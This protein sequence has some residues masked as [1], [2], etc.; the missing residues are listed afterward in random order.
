MLCAAYIHAVWAY[1]RPVWVYIHAV[2]VYIHAVCAHL[3]S[4][5]ST[6]LNIE[7]HFLFLPLK[8]V[9]SYDLSFTVV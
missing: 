7:L 4:W 9:T 6:T 2:W 8:K 5:A 3:L 1:I